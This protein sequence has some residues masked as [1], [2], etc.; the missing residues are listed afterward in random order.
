MDYEDLSLEKKDGIATITLNAPDKLNAITSAMERSLPLAIDEIARDDAVKVVIVTGAGRAFCAGGDIER[1]K[2]GFE[3]TLEETRYEHLRMLG[4]GVADGFPRLDK[5]VIAAIN[6]HCVGGGF[7]LALSCDIRIASEKAK[8]GSVFINIALVP[9][10]GMTYLLPHFVGT[11]KALELMFSGEIIDAVEAERL[12]I[13]SRVVPH[14]DLMKV[15]LELAHKIAQQP[16]AALE[17]T[18]KLVYRDMIN[19]IAHHLD[20]E[21]YAQQLC[22]ASED[23]RKRALAFLEKQPPP[24]PGGK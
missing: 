12:G 20:L 3:G 17:L 21:T 19:D 23:H 2:A 10:C 16:P 1:F 5:P 15:S 14:D 6:G 9:D 18:K 24:K 8:F 11:S 13:I 4:Q 22:F 7:S